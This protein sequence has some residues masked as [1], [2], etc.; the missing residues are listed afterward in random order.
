MPSH[1]YE[2]TTPLSVKKE[3]ALAILQDPKQFLI[4]GGATEEDSIKYDE[5]SGKWYGE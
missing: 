5:K 2:L 4:S 3:E 1:E